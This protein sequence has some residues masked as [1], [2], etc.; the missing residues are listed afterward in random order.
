[1]RIPTWRIALTG[2]AIV[3]LL[4]AGIG[5]VAAASNP[6][7]EPARAAL[8]DPTA[9]PGASGSPNAMDGGDKRRLGGWL[10]PK[11]DRIGRLA[12]GRHLV[13]VT[14]T[15][16]DKDG[17]LITIQLDH[18]TVQSIGGGSLAISEAGGTTVTVST[19]D[20]TVLRVGRE[21]R[22]LADLAVGDEIF[23]QSRIDGGTTL[24]KRIL[25]VPAATS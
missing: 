25:E 6:G 20:A 8:A 16:T 13:H 19:D 12:L 14:A 22:S 24:A 9:G 18:G 17:N 2:G 11:L 15:V 5:L 7:R 4:V 3:V 10:R 1:M 21:K 23:V